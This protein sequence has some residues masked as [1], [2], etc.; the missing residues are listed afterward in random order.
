MKNSAIELKSN[1]IMRTTEDRRN[2]FGCWGIC[3][4]AGS[5]HEGTTQKGKF[6]WSMRI[7]KMKV[8]MVIG[9]CQ[10]CQA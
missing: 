10:I 9:I 8:A 7:I 4:L 2:R 3:C 6:K 5:I 1:S